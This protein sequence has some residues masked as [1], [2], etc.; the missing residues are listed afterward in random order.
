[1]IDSVI[2]ELQLPTWFRY[3]IPGTL[4]LCSSVTVFTFTRSFALTGIG[5]M[6]TTGILWAIGLIPLWVFLVL[7]LVGGGST[8]L[9]VF[10]TPEFSEGGKRE[11]TDKRKVTLSVFGIP[12]KRK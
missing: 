2:T 10:V 4:I 12:L 1:M 8:V 6:V 11:V 7:G 5:T 9:R 3:L